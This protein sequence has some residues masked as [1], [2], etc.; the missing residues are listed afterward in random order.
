MVARSNRLANFDQDTL[1]GF[2]DQQFFDW[3]LWPFQ[4]VDEAL[5]A[6]NLILKQPLRSTTVFCVIG[7]PIRSHC[8]S[9]Q[10]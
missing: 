6:P 8:P 3:A 9:L 4:T 10:C 2:T 1:I 7:R 5:E